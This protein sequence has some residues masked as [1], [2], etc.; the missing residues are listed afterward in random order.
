MHRLEAQFFSWSGAQGP[1]AGDQVFAGGVGKEPDGD[2]RARGG[3]TSIGVPHGRAMT[4]MPSGGWGRR[5]LPWLPRDGMAW[6]ATQ[7]ARDGCR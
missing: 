7:P 3:E 1:S 4:G 2:L 6:D 5:W